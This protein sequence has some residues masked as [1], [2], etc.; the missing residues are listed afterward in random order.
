MTSLPD[1]QCQASRG[2]RTAPLWVG[3]AVC[4]AMFVPVGS[5]YATHQVMA[6]GTMCPHAKGELAPG[7]QPAS[8]GPARAAAAGPLAAPGRSAAPA[9]AARPAVRPAAKP[10]AQRPAQTQAQSGASSVE[11]SASARTGSTVKVGANASAPRQIAVARPSRAGEPQARRAGRSG[12]ATTVRRPTVPASVKGFEPPASGPL[13]APLAT[14]ITR[15]D[16]GVASERTIPA[17]LVAGL[18]LLVL[19][20]LAAATALYRRRRGSGAAELIA[21]PMAPVAPA[22]LDDPVEAELQEIIAE[23]TAREVVLEQEAEPT[24]DRRELTGSR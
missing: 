5:A 9:P 14:S 24:A 16:G 6:D 1:Y 13:P 20:G 7:E 17:A 21:Q 4:G 22:V 8:Q 19:G 2:R 23:A 10:A 11:S 12:P 18:G 3:V 15:P